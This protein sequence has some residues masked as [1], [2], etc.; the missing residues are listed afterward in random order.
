[1]H[2][3]EKKKEVDR[4][5]LTSRDHQFVQ[6]LSPPSSLLFRTPREPRAMPR[7]GAG[8]ARCASVYA[9]AT[10]GTR[11][12]AAG[13]PRAA[14]LLV[15]VLLGHCRADPPP[16]RLTLLSPRNGTHLAVGA[17]WH[18]EVLVSGA[19][20]GT[21]LQFGFRNDNANI[22]REQ[23]PLHDAEDGFHRYRIPALGAERHVLLDVRAIVPAQPHDTVLA[24]ACAWISFRLPDLAIF[25]PMN[26]EPAFI[27]DGRPLVVNF[28]LAACVMAVPDCFAEF[29]G[30]QYK[31]AQ[32]LVD[33]ETVETTTVHAHCTDAYLRLYMYT[34]TQI[35]TYVRT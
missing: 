35:R 27:A 2:F 4:V 24:V 18:I 13:A 28:G 32:V 31:H 25:H 8:H 11:A 23:I 7:A 3:E 15:L 16:A 33:E 9:V 26:S 29:Q 30:S 34:C 10:A 17:P 1:V 5:S 6:T 21:R 12:R 22:V 19:T 14:W 20:P